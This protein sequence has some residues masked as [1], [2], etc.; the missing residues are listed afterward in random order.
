L[1]LL[2]LLPSIDAT[3]G[4]VGGTDADVLERQKVLLLPTQP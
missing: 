1:P 2:R 3:L 4:G